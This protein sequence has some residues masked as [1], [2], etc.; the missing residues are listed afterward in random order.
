MKQL[1]QKPKTD[2]DDLLV[3]IVNV[4]QSARRTAARSVNSVMTTTYWFVGHRIVEHEQRGTARAAY[5]ERLLKHLARDLSGRFGRG[6]SKRNLEQMRAFYL[7]WPMREAT[8][9]EISAPAGKIRKLPIAQ[10]LSAQF[11]GISSDAVLHRFPLPW[12][13]YARLLAVKNADARAFYEHEALRGGWTI[14]QLDR[15]IQSQFYERTAL[16]R[17]KAAMLRKGTQPV[18]TSP[19]SDVSIGCA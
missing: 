17:D 15:Q 14:R 5:G 7:E 10:T 12:S 11:S 9:S 8:S 6:F 1:T 13:H 3:E 16:S 4:I 19:S 2:Y 18:A